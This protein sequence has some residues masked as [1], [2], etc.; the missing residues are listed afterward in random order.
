MIQNHSDEIESLDQ[1]VHSVVNESITFHDGAINQENRTARLENA[2]FNLEV[3][4]DNTENVAENL[5]NEIGRFENATSNQL[6]GNT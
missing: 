1:L 3:R 2:L 4:S 5:V 6:A